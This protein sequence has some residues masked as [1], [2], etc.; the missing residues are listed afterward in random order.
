MSTSI[1]STSREEKTDEKHPSSTAVESYTPQG[2]PHAEGSWFLRAKEE[3]RWLF[4]TRDGL[5]GDYESVPPNKSL[6]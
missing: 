6:W 4:T 1:S 5:L 3:A 2:N